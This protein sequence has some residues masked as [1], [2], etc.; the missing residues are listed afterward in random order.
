MSWCMDCLHVAIFGNSREPLGHSR[1][2]VVVPTLAST[3]FP[4]TGTMQGCLTKLS[5]LCSP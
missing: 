1:V 2:R 5:L 3:I 4:Q